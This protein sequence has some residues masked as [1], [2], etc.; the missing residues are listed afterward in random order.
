MNKEKF[1]NLYDF[2]FEMTRIRVA[3]REDVIKQYVTDKTINNVDT[4]FNKDM[5]K[6]EWDEYANDIIFKPFNFKRFKYAETKKDFIHAVKFLSSYMSGIYSCDL[7]QEIMKDA[8]CYI[9]TISSFMESDKVPTS[10]KE[11]VFL[12]FYDN[13]KE[14]DYAKEVFPL[15]LKR[16][17][18]SENFLKII[19]KDNPKFITDITFPFSYIGHIDNN[20]PQSV[21]DK[22]AIIVYFT[23]K[24]DMEYFN[25]SLRWISQKTYDELHLNTTDE[26]QIA[27]I[28]GN[29]NISEKIRDDLFDEFGCDPL[30]ASL[31]DI[32]PHIGEELSKQAIETIFDIGELSTS[33]ISK[34]NSGG[35]L[36]NLLANQSVPESLQIDLAYRLLYQN[37]R[38]SNK[39][40]SSLESNLIKTTTSPYVLKICEKFK[41]KNK[42]YVYLNKHCPQEL[43]KKRFQSQIAKAEKIIAKNGMLSSTKYCDDIYSIANSCELDEEQYRRIYKIERASPHPDFQRYLVL[44]NTPMSVIKALANENSDVDQD[45]RIITEFMIECEREGILNKEEVNRLFNHLNRFDMF[46]SINLK[47]KMNFLPL[48]GRIPFN[49]LSYLQINKVINRNIKYLEILN[50]IIEPKSDSILKEKFKTYLYISENTTEKEKKEAMLQIGS[51]VMFPQNFNKAFDKPFNYSEKINLILKNED[52][53]KNKMEYILG[54]DKENL[55]NHTEEER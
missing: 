46:S 6:K 15:I 29:E 2:V 17:D 39:D 37:N 5:S 25:P 48:C 7:P 11:R 13:F 44:P 27:F 18:I 24:I 35:I 53:I 21:I 54:K 52:E 30:I 47:E 26:K 33:G 49:N 12:S 23:P 28:L 34:V 32:T 55:E 8:F 31:G 14:T 50:N 41:N 42:E 22:E 43:L 4:I 9:C 10:V 3:T 1:L 51:R 45:V 40:T 20:I 19:T 16:E 38:S 36:Y